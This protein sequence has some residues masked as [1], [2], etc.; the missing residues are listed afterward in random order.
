MAGK[1]ITE[2]AKRR[3]DSLFEAFSLVAEDT[4]VYLCNMEYDYSR[5][6]KELVETFGLPS[7][8]MYDAGLIWEKHIHPDDRKSYREGLEAIFSGKQLG[9]DMQYRAKRPDGQY[10]ICTC[11]GLVI[12]DK[13]GNPYYFG[14]AI[15]NHSQRSHIDT[16]TGLRSQY[17]FFDDL[18]SY[19]RNKVPIRIGMI[20][21]GKLAEIN[22]VYG[23]HA[24]NAILQIFGRYLME[25]VSN[26]VGSYRL[27]GSRFAIISTA[28]NEKE[29]AEVYEEMRAHFRKGIKLDKLDVI[30]ELNAG[31]LS[32]NEFNVDDQTVYSCLNMA[33]EE[34]KL[35]KHGDMVTFRNELTG[36]SR[37]R[38][39]KLH[40]IRS[41]I[42]RNFSGFY[43]AYQPVLDAKTEKL[44]GAEALLRWKNDEY[45]VVPPDMFIPFL[46]KDPL[47]HKLGE[48]I[49]ET[50]LRDA[51][52]VM[53]YV[54][55]FVINVNLS[56]AQM[57][58]ADFTDTV[59]NTI[60]RA[61]FPKEQLCLEVTERCRLLDMELLKNVIVTLRAG[62]VRIALDD[63]G[64]GFSSVGLVKNLPFDTI[65]IDRSFVQNIE[66]DE[67]E[68]CLL[69]N[70][71]EMAS[72]YGAKVCVEGLE[73]SGM[74]DIIRDYGVHSFQGYYYSKPISIEEL[75]E[76]AKNGEDCFKK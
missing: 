61:G 71:T 30:L 52:K 36:E 12:S 20:G 43:L 53:E 7:E 48:W 15:R 8:Y 4:Y 31:M 1:M 26:R 5:W 14:G 68:K 24:G 55:G 62:G 19:I 64:T 56:Y 72:I 65:K 11:R 29:L 34:S 66:L 21:I 54:P 17:G 41:S 37:K 28:Q 51:L 63:F 59:W 13:D 27:D 18:K 75:L 69:N 22:E 76:K 6:S 40:A 38:L 57:E 47:F 10:D 33:Y 45:G 46:E 49:M 35:N 23:Y 60:L 16:L 9:H 58:K 42:A 73:T 50:A 74:R 44:I 25:H 67:R 39:E 3:L 32:L 2:E 70:F